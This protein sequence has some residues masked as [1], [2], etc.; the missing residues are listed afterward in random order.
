M[1]FG[2]TESL[3]HGAQVEL[4]TIWLHSIAQTQSHSMLRALPIIWTW[5]SQTLQ[6][7]SRWYT[8]E[9]P[10]FN[11]SIIG[12]R[13]TKK[14]LQPHHQWEKIEIKIK[15]KEFNLLI[16]N[17]SCSFLISSTIKLLHSYFYRLTHHNCIYALIPYVQEDPKTH[18]RDL[19]ILLIRRSGIHLYHDH[20]FILRVI[21]N[22]LYLNFSSGN[23]DT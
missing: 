13:T 15:F 5:E 2:S 10:K 8:Q 4:L 11:M 18:M 23:M 3:I 17:H 19:H 6:T 21:L 7:Q 14:I 9:R 20:G 22:H 12:S 1:L 16:R